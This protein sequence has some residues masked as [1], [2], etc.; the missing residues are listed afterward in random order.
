ML[1]TD[2]PGVFERKFRKLKQQGA[3]G[4]NRPELY[5]DSFVKVINVL[6]ELGLESGSCLS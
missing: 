5:Q 2:Y 6:Q 1:R 4:Y 3:S